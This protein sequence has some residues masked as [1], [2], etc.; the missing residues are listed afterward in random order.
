[1]DADRASDR[2]ISLII[3]M[4]GV[5][6]VGYSGSLVK[7]VITESLFGLKPTYAAVQEA[8]EAE[9][10]KVVVG[11]SIYLVLTRR[12]AHQFMH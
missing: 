12:T 7:D 8:E 5:A 2:W 3:V 10:G 9:A 11:Q 1:M 4:A 6:L